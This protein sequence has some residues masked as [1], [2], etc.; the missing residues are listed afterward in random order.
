MLNL[1][2]KCP[3]LFGL[4][5]KQLTWGVVKNVVFLL[6]EITLGALAA[7]GSATEEN[8]FGDLVLDIE[9]LLLDLF[10]AEVIHC[11]N[12]TLGIDSHHFTL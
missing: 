8:H 12:I 1:F 3:S 2:A 6:N 11:L 10:Q 5:A 4:L 9:D 7:A